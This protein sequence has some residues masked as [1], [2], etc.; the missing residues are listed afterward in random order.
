LTFIAASFLSASFFV[1]SS[2]QS[3]V[4]IRSASASFN[5]YE[6]ECALFRLGWEIKADVQ[7]AKRITNVAI[8]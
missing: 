7:L 2:I 5:C 1:G 3:S 6:F 4:L 8:L